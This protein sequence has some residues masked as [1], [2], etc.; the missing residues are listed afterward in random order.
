MSELN[1]STPIDTDYLDVD[2]YNTTNQIASEQIIDEDTSDSTVAD[3]TGNGAKSDAEEQIDQDNIIVNDGRS[4]TRTT[5]WPSDVAKKNSYQYNKL[6]K[7]ASWNDGVMASNRPKQ[8]SIADKNRQISVVCG[9]LELDDYVRDRV[10]YLYDH[11]DMSRHGPYGIEQ[12]VLSTIW[13]VVAE[14]GRDLTDN[15]HFMEICDT[16]DIGVST[17]NSSVN[18]VQRHMGEN[19]IEV[20]EK[21]PEI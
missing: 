11:I 7:L 4:L 2:N 21:K 17:L 1:I 15:E 9:K 20:T 14:L 5:F 3:S 10:S 8:N 12:L 18:L 16:Y 6:A 13:I 19:D